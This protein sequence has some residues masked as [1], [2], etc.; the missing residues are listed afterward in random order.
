MHTFD[1]YDADMNGHYLRKAT[2]IYNGRKDK[3]M[4]T[5]IDYLT[6]DKGH[7]SKFAPPSP[8]YI[9]MSKTPDGT[10]SPLVVC[11]N[12]TDKKQNNKLIIDKPFAWFVNNG[13]IFNKIKNLSNNNLLD[14]MIKGDSDLQ[15]DSIFNN[16]LNKNSLCKQLPEPNDEKQTGIGL[17][18]TV[19][20]IEMLK[21]QK[22]NRGGSY[23]RELAK[24]YKKPKTRGGKKK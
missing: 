14:N 24:K 21:K 17:W 8:K 12:N 1:K 2:S 10:N 18:N 4:S 22:E 20:E 9:D 5:Y 19:K 16:I 7:D 13:G 23:R 3:S 11:K 6:G 15:R